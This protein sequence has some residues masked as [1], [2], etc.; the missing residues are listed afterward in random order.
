MRIIDG[1]NMLHREAQNLG[2]GIH[3]VRTIFTK[4]L[5]PRETTIIVWDGPHGNKRRQDLFFE[6]KQNRRPKEESKYAFFDM[7]KGVI[8]FTP[9]LQVECPGWE[10]DDVIGSLVDRYH[11]D[12]K[13]TV[14]TNDGDYWQHSDKCYLPLVSAKKWGWMT[15]DECLLYKSLVGDSKDNIPGLKGFGDLTFKRTSPAAR[16]MMIDAIKKEDF[17]TWCR[18][19]GLP[20]RCSVNLDMFKR[21][22]LFWK[23]NKAFDVPIQEINDATF[24]GKLN[25]P[26]AEIYMERFMI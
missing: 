20:P 12:H 15:P 26:A 25:I 8:R 16:A 13:I 3:P 18:I 23:L 9:V 24:L 14:E 2:R 22:C 17:L 19:E 10:A 6:Y 7:A 21:I 5:A 4:F 1:N 11:K